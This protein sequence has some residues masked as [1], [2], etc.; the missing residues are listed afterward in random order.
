[1]HQIS[2]ILIVKNA[3]NTLQKCLQVLEK[4]EE[5]VVLI[6]DSTT[7]DSETI[8]KSFINT[9]VYS[10]P[11]LGFGKMKQKA[12]SFATKNWIFSVD[13]DEVVSDE[14]L[15]EIGNLDLREKKNIYSFH[16]KNFYQNKH[17]DACGWNNDYV[18]RLYDKTHTTFVDKN[19]HEYVEVKSESKVIKLNESILHFPYTNV[20]GLIDK[21]NHYSDLFAEENFRKKKSSTFKSIYK[22][23]YT[24]VKDYFFRKGIFYGSEGFLI[25]LCNANGA[26]YKYYKLKEKNKTV[27]ISL[28][29]TTYNRPEALNLVLMSALAQSLLPHEIIIADDGS[30]EST[31]DLIAGFQDQRLVPIYHVWQPDEGFKLSAI[32]NKAIAQAKGEFICMIDGDLLLHND[33]IQII[34]N[35]AVRNTF[36]QGKR[37]LL[38][39]NKTEQIILSEKIP[40]ITFFSNGFKNR[41]NTVSSKLLSSILSKRINSIRAVKGCSMHFWKED[42][43]AVNGFNEDFIGWGREDSEFVSRLLNYGVKRKNIILGAVG[44][45]LH[46]Q[47]ASRKMLPENDL[48]LEQTLKFKK[49]VCENGI[50]KYL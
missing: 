14:L 37:V 3:S 29:I 25:S 7:D 43:L 48:I 47:E 6:D 44:Y 35:M 8:A 20:K 19:I 42:A 24:F 36:Y 40:N 30:T 32:R 10:S 21:M 26:F 31:K 41:L 13:S 27:K 16:R 1:M 9:K 17:I 4:F 15:L 33:F 2:V 38:D 22:S 49:M 46:H 12:E 34:E 5:I 11:F 39:E 45:H 28:L 18:Q 23:I 50:N